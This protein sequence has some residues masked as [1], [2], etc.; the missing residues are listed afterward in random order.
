MDTTV[1]NQ[2][3]TTPHQNQIPQNLNNSFIIQRNVFLRITGTIVLFTIV[4]AISYY[5]GLQQNK[6]VSKQP[7]LISPS[8]LPTNIKQQYSYR[9]TTITS[10]PLTANRQVI[11]LFKFELNLPADWDIGEVNRRPA[12]K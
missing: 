11:D 2:N 10:A 4:A 8:P 1:D 12:P 7:A 3:I 6:Y 9:P 5:L